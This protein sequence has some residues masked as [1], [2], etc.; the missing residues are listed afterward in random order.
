[1]TATTKT[2]RT[3]ELLRKGWLTAMQCA[4]QGGCWALSQRVSELRAAGTNVPDKWVETAGGARIKA[5]R[6]TGKAQKAAV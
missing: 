2:A 5:Y 6:I 1:M 3:I 4:Q